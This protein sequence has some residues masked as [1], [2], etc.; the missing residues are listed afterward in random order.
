M[1]SDLVLNTNKIQQQ[2]YCGTH[3]CILLVYSVK[4]YFLQGK[5]YMWKRSIL[6]MRFIFLSTMERQIRMDSCESE[7][8]CLFVWG[9]KINSG[10]PSWK[11]YLI[12]AV[13]FKY[14]SDGHSFRM[15]R[16][17]IYQFLWFLFKFIMYPTSLYTKILTCL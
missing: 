14:N 2:R 4:I 6:F 10:V 13:R 11:H 7:K 9:C 5:S 8:E 17:T 3:E 12:W 16:T 15:T 1:T